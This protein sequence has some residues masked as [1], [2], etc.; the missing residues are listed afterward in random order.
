MRRIKSVLDGD[1]S[2]MSSRDYIVLFSEASLSLS[3]I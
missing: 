2:L 1:G 3:G